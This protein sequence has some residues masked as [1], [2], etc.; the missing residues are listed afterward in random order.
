MYLKNES[1]LAQQNERIS[2]AEPYMY[3]MGL[4]GLF[5]TGM[6]QFPHVPGRISIRVTYGSYL[7]I[8]MDQCILIYDFLTTNLCTSP[9]L[10]CSCINSHG[11]FGY[12]DF[13]QV[14]L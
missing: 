14:F 9:L 4:G 6:L 12:I 10:L 5:I 13:L 1:R 3:S 8:N 7:C 11:F 2:M